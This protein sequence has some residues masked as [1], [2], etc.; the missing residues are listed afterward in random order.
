MRQD[1]S[2]GEFNQMS[3]TIPKYHPLSVFMDEPH[4]LLNQDI[5]H[6]VIRLHWKYSK[7]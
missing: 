7:A 2:E 5:A 1:L 6:N 4:N 3:L